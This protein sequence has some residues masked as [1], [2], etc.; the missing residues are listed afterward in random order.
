MGQEFFDQYSLLHFAVGII[1]AFLEIPLLISVFVHVLFEFVENTNLGIRFIN[2]Y[3]S[4][5]WPGGKPGPDAVINSIGDT[6]SFIFG[7]LFAWVIIKIGEKH[8][9]YLLPSARARS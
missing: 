9:W 3:L 7:W 6:L 8:K 2:N 4:W 1:F 5:L